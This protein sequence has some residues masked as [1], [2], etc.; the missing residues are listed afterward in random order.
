MSE[1]I[2]PTLAALV[3]QVE[4]ALVIYALV[5]PTSAFWVPQVNRRR[6]NTPK[7]DRYEGK[8]RLVAESSRRFNYVSNLTRD[9]PDVRKILTERVRQERKK[10]LL[11]F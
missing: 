11:R 1:I 8:D 10:R 3:R 6:Y 5:R 4:A 2:R 9:H 7:A